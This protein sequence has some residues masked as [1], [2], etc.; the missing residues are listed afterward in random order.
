MKARLL[1][2]FRKK[3][4]E[5][6]VREERSQ[7]TDEEGLLGISFSDEETALA[8]RRNAV[9]ERRFALGERAEGFVDA[10][11]P[12]AAAA[13]DAGAQYGMAVVRFP[14]GVGWADLCKSPHEGYKLLSNFKDGKF[15][16]MAAI[17]QV[18]LQGPAVANLALQG[19]A[20]VVGQAY[21]AQINEQLAG[22]EAGIG[23]LERAMELERQAKLRSA[24]DMAKRY[25]LRF[26]EFQSSDE[27]R[28]AARNQLEGALKDSRGMWHYQLAVLGDLQTEVSSSKKMKEGEIL[29]SVRKL[30]S[31]EEQAA[32]AFQLQAVIGQM[33][34]QYD[35]DFSAAR[36]EAERSDL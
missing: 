23:R 24:Y 31:A 22:I 36:I 29:E 15:N 19:A 14:D 20:V 35:C 26:D 30:R 12:A 17:K 7:V 3:G 11:I 34:M 5:P 10:M 21:M 18:G 6:E 2:F 9:V 13:V 32:A 1:D 25:A 28:I 27:K 16:E 4:A 8:L 33:C